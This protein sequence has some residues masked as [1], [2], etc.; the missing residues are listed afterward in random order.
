[1][2]LLKTATYPKAKE[3][4]YKKAYKLK[5]QSGELVTRVLTTSR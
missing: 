4:S 1:M 2:K 5:I 3:T